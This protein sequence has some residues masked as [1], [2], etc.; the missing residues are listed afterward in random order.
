MHRWREERKGS[1]LYSDSPLGQ[2]A[3][4]RDEL[5]LLHTSPQE[6]GAGIPVEDA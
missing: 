1:R 6:A 4:G 3:A 5:T 2:T